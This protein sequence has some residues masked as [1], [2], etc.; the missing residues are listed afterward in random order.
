MSKIKKSSFYFREIHYNSKSATNLS[1]LHLNR[2]HPN[3][4][5]DNSTQKNLKRQG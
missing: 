5:V 2:A 4:K 3:D 1:L